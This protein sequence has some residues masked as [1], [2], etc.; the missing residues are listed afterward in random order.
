MG[1]FSW[2]LF[3]LAFGAYIFIPTPVKRVFGYG[4]LFMAF[5]AYAKTKFFLSEKFF[6]IKK[7]LKGFRSSDAFEN[8]KGE[9]I[10]DQQKSDPEDPFE[11]TDIPKENIVLN[12][13][14]W[15]KI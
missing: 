14:K 5:I 10:K 1:T 4:L 9:V 8:Y 11:K 7:W 13:E 12:Y 2:M 3:G 6:K 15:K